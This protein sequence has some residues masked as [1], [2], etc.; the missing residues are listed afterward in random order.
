MHFGTIWGESPA[1]EQYYIIFLSSK[2]C[3]NGKIAVQRRKDNNF[4][5][6]QGCKMERLSNLPRSQE[7]GTLLPLGFTVSDHSPEK[8]RKNNGQEIG[9]RLI[10]R[11]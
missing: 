11:V 5:T 3:F 2:T 1:A 7:H 10:A 8:K 4:L 6:F 9:L